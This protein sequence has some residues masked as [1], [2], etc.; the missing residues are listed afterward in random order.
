MS[1]ATEEFRRVFLPYCIERVE[2]H[3][4]VVLNRLYKPLGMRTEEHV[5]YVPHAVRLIGLTPGKAAQLSHAHSDSTDRIHLYADAS[6]PT[7]S[8]ED[9]DAYQRKLGLLATLE[10]A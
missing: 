3:G 7:R 10:I 2:D 5:D 8:P 9:W 1:T 6:A 4:H